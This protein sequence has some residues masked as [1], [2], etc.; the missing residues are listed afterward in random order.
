MLTFPT[1]FLFIIVQGI[2]LTIVCTIL[3][4][5]HDFKKGP[6]KEGCRKSVVGFLFSFNAKIWMIV[7]GVSS[8]HEKMD[9]DYTPYLGP[10]YKDTQPVIKRV[11]TIICN[12]VSWIDT[13][14]LYQ[15][16][17]LAFTLDIGFKNAPLMSNLG[18]IVDS[19]YLPRGG[20]EEK[21][22]AALNMIK[23]RQELI[24]T[25]GEYTTLL[26]FPEGGT[27]NGSGLIK[28]KK[29]AFYGEKSV[30]PVVLKYALDESVS[31]AYDTIEILPLVIFQLS[32]SCMTCRVIELPD[33]QPN[34]YLFTEH[35]DK[36]DERWEIYAW[37]TRD[38]MAKVGSFDLCDIPLREKVIYEGYMQMN[39]KY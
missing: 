11:S 28:F 27:T 20:T 37:A 22:L 15:F 30:K 21:K 1:R 19:I 16:F 35:A 18:N 12:H 36:G 34:E 26:V 23:D 31:V 13:Q 3:T 14:N 39:P 38:I 17:K 2:L 32:W 5:G 7:T 6:L 33:F 10:N 24:E 9:F 4:L 8:K 29:G 25:T